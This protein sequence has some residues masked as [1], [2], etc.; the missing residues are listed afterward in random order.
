MRKPRSVGSWG[1]SVRVAGVDVDE[2]SRSRTDF[3]LACRVYQTQGRFSFN[4]PIQPEAWRP[5][6]LLPDLMR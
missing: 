2:S 3:G 5:W 1:R 6:G 4:P